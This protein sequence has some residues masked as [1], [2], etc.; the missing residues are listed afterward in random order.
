MRGLDPRIHLQ[1]RMD[2]RV[3]P[4][5]DDTGDNLEHKRLTLAIPA[6]I[7]TPPGTS[8]LL[9]FEWKWDNDGYDTIERRP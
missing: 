3:K 7:S 6:A 1:K 2:C 9:A 8:G 4:G 5:N